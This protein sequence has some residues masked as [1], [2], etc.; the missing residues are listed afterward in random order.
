[1]LKPQGFFLVSISRGTF[2]RYTVGCAA[3]E[4][5]PS[6]QG[7]V[8]HVFLGPRRAQSTAPAAVLSAHP[9]HVQDLASS[10]LALLEPA[11]AGWKDLIC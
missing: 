5:Q 4:D 9:G 10:V 7:V 2:A 8:G 11:V 1:M 3:I 6:E